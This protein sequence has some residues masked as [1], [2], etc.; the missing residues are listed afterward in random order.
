MLT[1]VAYPDAEVAAYTWVGSDTPTTG[2]PLLA[3]ASDP[4]YGDA[5]ALTSYTYNYNAVFNFGGGPYLIT[6]TVLEEKNLSTGA[7][8][9]SLPLGGGPN[10]QIVQGNGSEVTRLYDKG[11]ISGKRDGAGRLTSFTRSSGGFGYIASR[12]APNGGVTTYTRDFAGRLLTETDPYGATQT[13]AY[14]TAGFVI[15]STDKLGRLTTITRDASNRPTRVDYPDSTYETWTYNATGQLLSHR[16]ADGGIQ[17]RAYY[18]AG[19]IGGHL[20]DLK[21]VADPLGHLTTYTHSP[22]GQVLTIKDVLNR[23]TTHAY[24]PGGRQFRVTHP[25]ATLRELDYDDFGNVIQITDELGHATTYTYNEYQRVSSVTDPLARTTTYQYGLSPSCSSCGYVDTL[26]RITYPSGR[27]IERTYDDSGLLL[28]EID[29]AGTAQAA[30]TTLAYSAS[31]E[32]ASQTDPLGQVTSYTYDLL[33]RRVTTTDPLNR[34]TTFSY[35][36]VGNTL[37]TT[38]ADGAVTTSSYDVRNRLATQTDAQGNVIAYSYDPEGRLATLTDA[39]SALT[40][41]TYD[42]AG[43]QTRK[44]YA[45]ATYEANTYDAVGQRT[46]FRTPAGIT[47][48]CTYDQRGRELTCDWNDSTPN[49]A[50]AYDAASRLITLTTSG[51]VTHTYAYDV[52]GQLLSE[53]TAPIALAPAAFTVA[54]TYD[55]DGRRTQLTYPDTDSVTYA[56]TARGQVASISAGGPPPLATFAYD[57]DGRRTQ[58]VLENGVTTTYT[59]DVAHQLTT[60]AHANSA[61]TLA[62]FAYT[63]DTGGRRT[64]K[65]MTG[66]AVVA[67]SETYGYD[68]IDQVTTAGYGSAG[69]ESFAYDAMGNRTTASLLGV[70]SVSYSANSL[71]QYTS[72]GGS[73]PTYDINGNTLTLPNRAFAYDGQSR[74]KS[75]TVGI[76]GLAGYHAASFVYDARNRQVSRTVDGITTY[77]IWDGWSLLAEY[78][79]I[80]GTPAQTARYVHG[81]RLDEILVQARGVAPTPV[82]LHEDALGSTYLLTN[83]SGAMVERYAYTAFGEVTAFNASGASVATPTTRFLYT[84]REWI[85]ELGLNDHRNRFYL[86]SIGRWLSKDPIGPLGPDGPNL[87]KYVRNSPTNYVDPDGRFAINAAAGGVGAIFGGVAGGII[88]AGR[89]G[90]GGLWRGTV[91]GA[92]GGFVSGATFNPALGSAAALTASGMLAGALGGAVSNVVGDALD[93]CQVVTA[94]RVATSAAFGALGGTLTGAVSQLP[95]TIAD[96]MISG[97]VSANSE[98][99]G[100]G[101][102]PAAYDAWW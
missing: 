78:R 95:R 36:A 64:A 97:A 90:W 7:T 31:G 63:Y 81:P 55:L 71:N 12:T 74:M 10:A 41:W 53:T 69:N 49:V 37:T 47:L 52:A 35:D 3:T 1:T 60:L 54:Y 19:E 99:Y 50:R 2:R 79:I 22:A 83:A 6:G 8:I 65:A 16:R 96:D 38:R 76:P 100:S 62:S 48:T 82:Y 44:T 45:D 58:K 17:T 92:V 59:Y 40:T 46:L 91:A 26:T 43:R 80:G 72:L 98:I 85:A 34:Q 57:L 88:S 75:T 93:P 21:T 61:G 101:V 9:V 67:R 18:A 11:Q 51:V 24:T 102:G 56:Y 42:L 25:D 28:T 4:M 66:S 14:N 30:T 68:A 70:G 20:G 39:R 32:L 15:S 13:S 73:A 29:G 87:Y 84:G 77:F 33:R 89:G 94:G 86:P 23:T 27:K 5:G